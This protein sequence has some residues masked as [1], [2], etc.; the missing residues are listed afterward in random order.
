MSLRTRALA[1]LVYSGLAAAGVYFIHGHASKS[2][3]SASLNASCPNPATFKTGTQLPYT[4]LGGLDNFLCILVTFFQTVLADPEGSK[5]TVNFI[6]QFASTIPLMMFESVRENRSLV[7]A[8]PALVGAM[9]QAAGGGVILPLYWLSFVLSGAPQKGFDISQVQAESALFGFLAGAAVPTVSMF[10]NSSNPHVVATWQAF[11]II[12][13][14][15]QQA[16][17]LLRPT[18]KGGNN[19]S[20]YQVVQLTHFLTFTAGAVFHLGVHGPDLLT[21]PLQTLSG[22]TSFFPSI[23]DPNPATTAPI[24]AVLDFLGWDRLLITTATAITPL[25]ST[26]DF[27]EALKLAGGAILTSIVLGPGAAVAGLWMYR[28]RAFEVQR[29]LKHSQIKRK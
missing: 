1:T 23:H 12:A 9:Y 22:I 14:A 13:G 28:E 17:I 3:L 24:D 19:A 26:E 2:G 11:P 18:P 15:F 25:F 20:G 27:G 4:G 10:M 7:L 6:A 29:A 16:Y 8:S 21:H 5:F